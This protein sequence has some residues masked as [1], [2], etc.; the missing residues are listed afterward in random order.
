VRCIWGTAD[1]FFPIAK[2]RRMLEQFPAGA[3]LVEIPGA[4]L[5]AHEDHPDAFV[6]HALPFLERC[7]GDG[8]E[9]VA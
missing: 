1:P 9:R 4:K 7:L 6:A 3:E 8:V 5:F 2:A